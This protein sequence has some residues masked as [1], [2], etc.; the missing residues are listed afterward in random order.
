VDILRKRIPFFDKEGNSPGTLTA[1][2]ST[3]SS[4][5]QQ[6]LGTEMGMSGVAIFAIIGS[7]IISFI[8]G[9]K[10]SLVGVLTV[11]PLLLIMG[12]FRVHLEAD[13]ERLNALVFAESSQV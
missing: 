12:Y 5:L 13:F 8:F 6:L 3:D 4:Q 11:M 9:W 1:R 7:I 2:L 10:L